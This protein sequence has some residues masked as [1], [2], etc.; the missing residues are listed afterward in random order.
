MS[1]ISVKESLAHS[2]NNL[3]KCK[4]HRKKNEES[5]ENRKNERPGKKKQ[6]Q[7]LINAFPDHDD[8]AEGIKPIKKSVCSSLEGHCNITVQNKFCASKMTDI[9]LSLFQIYMTQYLESRRDARI[10]KDFFARSLFAEN[11]QYPWGI[12]SY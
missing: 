9:I 5:G 8:N 11:L 4:G 2:M 7:M 12:S 3:A 1:F 6:H 10:T